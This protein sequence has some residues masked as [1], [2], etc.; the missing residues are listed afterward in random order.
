M[1]P[2]TKVGRTY[3]LTL[4]FAFIAAGTWVWL[5]WPRNYAVASYYYTEPKWPEFNADIPGHRYALVRRASVDLTPYATNCTKGALTDR[6]SNIIGAEWRDVWLC[7]PAM[8]TEA[9]FPIVL[10]IFHEFVDDD[11][12]DYYWRIAKSLAS[13][14]ATVIAAWVFLCSIIWS[15]IWVTRGS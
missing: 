3:L 4:V 13:K 10:Q 14:L 1:G 9:D 2:T 15:V 5:D 11:Y 7:N 8:L 12:R 6:T